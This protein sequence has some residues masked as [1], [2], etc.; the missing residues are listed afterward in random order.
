MSALLLICTLGCDTQA[1]VDADASHPYS[2]HLGMNSFFPNAKSRIAK[3]T[4]LP[5]DAGESSPACLDGSPFGFYFAPSAFGSTKWTISI[6]GGGWCYDEQSCYKRS[7]TTLGSSRLWNQ[8]AFCKCMN[9]ANGTIDDDC[10]CIYMPYCDGASFSGYR[11]QRWP[12]PG[13]PDEFLT[14]RGIKNFD[15][16]IAWALDHG[17]DSTTSEFVL[18]GGSAGGLSTFLHSDRAAASIQAVAPACKV[19][20]APV[21]G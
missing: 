20:S 5:Q 11:P 1:E 10:N 18:T 13:Y 21:V 7:N 16:T 17:L 9:M 6:E 4:L 19:R 8:T 12:V 14:F 3:L 15:Q 2:P